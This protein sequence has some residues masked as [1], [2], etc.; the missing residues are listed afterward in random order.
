MNEHE[1]ERLARGLGHRATE[2]LDVEATARAVVE[3]LRETPQ[4][5][6]VTW[7]PPEWLRI[8]AVL[9]LLLGA[10]V[11]LR[12]VMT[13]PPAAT[14]HYTL[15]DLGDLTVSE[16]SQMLAGLDRTLAGDGEEEGTLDWDDLTPA[17]LQAL[18]RS[19]ET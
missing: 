7:I 4:T 19:L 3:R 12:N 9:A 5:R 15:E 8:A 11:V 18:L 14:L 16:L 17:Q 2:R 1:L 6:R 13:P 10:G